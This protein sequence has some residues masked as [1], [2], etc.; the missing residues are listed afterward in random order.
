M[1]RVE[2]P[3]RLILQIEAGPQADPDQ[4]DRQTRNL[5]RE[6]RELHIE[7]I[8]PVRLENP[9]PAA[10]A[11]EAI[12]LG[13]VV[14]SV[15]PSILETVILFLR[16]W[17]KRGAD[18]RVKLR[19]QVGDSLLEIEYDPQTMTQESLQDLINTLLKDSAPQ[20]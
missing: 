19:F 8:A 9:P 18:R 15:L 3:I 16:D 14:V 4:I 13:S 11:G 20:S 17:S 6:L 2:A 7:S 5:I 10:K 12:A 1:S